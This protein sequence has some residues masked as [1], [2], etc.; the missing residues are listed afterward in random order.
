LIVTFVFSVG[1]LAVPVLA[2]GV[3][4]LLVVL[5]FAVALLNFLLLCHLPG[6]ALVVMALLG[7]CDN[8]LVL[9][10]LVSW[11]M[12]VLLMPLACPLLLLVEVVVH[13][14]VLV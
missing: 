12:L 14:L 5:Q 13:L 11:P 8:L 4:V 6:V 7:C 1:S 9:W 10:P 3:P 2:L